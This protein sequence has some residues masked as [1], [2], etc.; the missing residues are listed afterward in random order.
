MMFLLFESSLFQNFQLLDK[1]T[2]RLKCDAS[3]SAN[4][5]QNVRTDGINAI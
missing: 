4:P 3:L 1:L 2:I 5:V